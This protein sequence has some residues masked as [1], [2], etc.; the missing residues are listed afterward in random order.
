MTKKVANIIVFTILTFVVLC[1]VF[2][3]DIIF[4][5]G[6]LATRLDELLNP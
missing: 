2:Y 6:G 3:A 4:C 5:G 1:L